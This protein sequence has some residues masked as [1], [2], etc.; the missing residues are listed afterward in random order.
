MEVLAM[1]LERPGELVERGELQ[2]RLW[3]NDT[4][5]E[6]EH[7]INAAVKALR[8]ALNDSPDEPRYIET[9]PRRGYRFICPLTGIE[10]RR[11]G[12]PP[13]PPAPPAEPAI[14]AP[15]LPSDFTHSDLINRTVSHYRI[16]EKLGGGGMGVVYMAEDIRL[17]R[18]VALKF[19]P[20]GLAGHPGALARFEREARAASA[21]NHPHICTI[22]EIEEVDG[23]PFLAMELMEGKTLKHVIDGGAG[24]AAARGATPVP[25]GGHPQG[26]PLPAPQLLDLAIQIADGLEAAHAAGIIHRD[27]KPANI[28]VTK[29]G[30][31]KILDFGLAKFTSGLV[32]ASPEGNSP[33]IRDVLQDT[34]TDATGRRELTLAGA[35]MGTVAYMS[36]EQARG[37]EVD[38]R[39]DLFSFGAVLY[40]MATGRQAFSGSSSGE[41]R[42]AILKRQAT[43]ARSLNPAVDARLQAIIEKALEKDR[44]VRYQH[45]AEMRADL[46]RLKRDTDSG[47]SAAVPAAQQG[48]G[49][50]VQAPSGSGR[51]SRQDAGGTGNI[52]DSQ[53]V[54]RL[55]KRQQKAFFT[56]M[57]GG[58]VIVAALVFSLLHITRHASAPPPALEITRVTGTG[59][60]RDADISPDGKYVAYKRTTA[61]KS[62][63]WLKQL[64]TDSDIQIAALG[65]DRCAGLAF[66]PDGI[67]IYFVREDPHLETGDLEQM[68]FLGGTPR[69]MMAGI[70][71]PP[72]FSPDGRR[73]AFLR[74][75]LGDT[76]L[77]TATLDGSDERVLASYRGPRNDRVAWS[78]DGKTLAVF[79][80]TPPLAVLATIAAE[81]GPIHPVAGVTWDE[82]ADLAWLPDS[83]HLVVA[84]RPV[85]WP[86]TRASS[87]LYEVPV[88]GGEVKQITHDLTIYEGV[89]ASADGKT[90]LALHDQVFT[91]LQ[92]ATPGKEAE[93]RTLSV[94][95]QS[96][97]GWRSLAWIPD[98]KIVYVSAPNGRF[99]LW[100]VGADGSN[101]HRLTDTDE[102]TILYTPTVSLQGGVIAFTRWEGNGESTVWRMDMD[103]GNMKQLT[104]GKSDMVPALSPD[105]RWVIFIREESVKFLLM[106]VPSVGGP[107]AELTDN[108]RDNAYAPTVS[109]DGNWIACVYYP[110]GSGAP[111]LAI[112]PFAG[113]PPVKIFTHAGYNWVNPRWTR[114]GRAISFV[115]NQ[116]GLDNGAANIWEQ[117]VAGGAPKQVTHFTSENIIYCYDWSRDGRLALSRGSRPSEAVLIR[118]FQ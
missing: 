8:R 2:R 35:A 38:A 62:G 28:F 30:D 77:L 67:Y 81:G 84:G 18:K 74:E 9:L 45:A 13:P 58:F 12:D 46:K 3:P 42:E 111:S 102:S 95:N 26:S 53:M 104:E 31:A 19:L 79:H 61:G 25:A 91:T 98:G 51:K 47:H 43:P 14:P 117:P 55:K 36:P 76:K 71:G 80:F 66:S 85:G 97:D 69:K 41:I 103:G 89:R 44:E 109:P 70:S 94:G 39:T 110:H 7:S 112:I 65:D 96:F 4:V 32:P 92:V 108:D 56:L 59:D 115:H 118:N 17:G 33:P 60:I 116:E 88:E 34:P 87:Q 23:H 101:R 15:P 63:L 11:D 54:A 20:S 83:R 40:E 78:P 1:L 29:R 52:S 37:E 100:E 48:V 5:V 73:I 21:L 22:Y 107:A 57:A 68:P 106:K 27:I 10:A 105:G 24:P 90:L 114:D 82:L 93:A 99:N 16:L 64:A 75:H 49:P 86:G 72:A 6:F 113:G 50:P